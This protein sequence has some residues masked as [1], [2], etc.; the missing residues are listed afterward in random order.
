MPRPTD[1]QPATPARSC[2]G[3]DRVSGGDRPSPAKPA[4]DEVAAPPLWLLMLESSRA[5]TELTTSWLSRPLWQKFPRGDDHPVLLFPGFLA[6]DLSTRPLRGFLRE[7]G[8]RAHPWRQG[9]NLGLRDRLEDR[10]LQRVRELRRRS[11]RKVSLIGWSLGGV[12]AREVARR[13]PDDVRL[14]ISMGS[15]FG[16]WPK[17]N[18]SWRLFEWM[19]GRDVD[20][21]AAERAAEMQQPPPVP[22]TAIYSKSDGV[23]AWQSCLEQPGPTSENVEVPASHLG[24]G[25]N[26]LTFYVIADRLAQR[27]DGW[28]PFERTGL[29]QVLYPEPAVR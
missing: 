18:H 6:S 27:E 8:Y 20:E 19:S 23:T 9:R 3:D 15:P 14:V 4:T 28:R 26:P 25:F 11:G 13:S 22:A 5:F 12:F 7:L 24:L 10:L 17:A 1:T 16:G 21:I 2:R 29:L